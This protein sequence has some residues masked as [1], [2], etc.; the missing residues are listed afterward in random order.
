MGNPDVNPEPS[1]AEK[2]GA[3]ITTTEGS[4]ESH[5]A[6]GLASI[7][8]EAEAHTN[9]LDVQI[10]SQWMDLYEAENSPFRYKVDD[11]EF[12]TMPGKMRFVTQFSPGRI[13]RRPR[14]KV[15][16]VLVHVPRQETDFGFHK[17]SPVEFLPCDTK[18]K[19][20]INVSPIVKYH[21]LYLPPCPPTQEQ[22][23]TRD[24]L[25]SAIEF[26]TTSSAHVMYNSM[27]AGASVNALHFQGMYIR[28]MPVESAAVA[29]SWKHHGVT[30]NELEWPILAVQLS[31]DNMDALTDSAFSFI[32]MIQEANCGHNLLIRN[33]VVTVFARRVCDVSINSDMAA[34]QI[35]SLEA[36]GYWLFPTK[37]LFGESTE[38]DLV[39]MMKEHDV[40]GE[41]R[42]TFF[43]AI[44]P[45]PEQNA[46]TPVNNLAER[47]NYKRHRDLS[48]CDNIERAQKVPRVE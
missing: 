19:I 36:T 18:G 15:D 13:H 3:E 33:G 35:A 48:F 44:L 25:Q 26:S 5:E 8:L 46:D 21:F 41:E 14:V 22:F 34:L 29:R 27:G 32:K 17:A 1:Q 23:I 2:G 45:C 42:T 20:L 39:S 43:S 11:D 38:D 6:V 47:R 10:R 12:A 37:E 7:G 28:E 24:T 16:K 30:I 40:T 31:S 4:V 9:A